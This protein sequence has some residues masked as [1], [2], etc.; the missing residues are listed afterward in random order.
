[1]DIPVIDLTSLP[2]GRGFAPFVIR[3]V[4]SNGD[5]WETTCYL[6]K[7]DVN[8]TEDRDPAFRQLDEATLMK[9][10]LLCVRDPPVCDINVILH[11]EVKSIKGGYT[12]VFSK[13]SNSRAQK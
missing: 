5:I 9:L 11:G 1:M 3:C 7:A 12:D 8:I 6:T 10:G 13:R 4:D 2:G